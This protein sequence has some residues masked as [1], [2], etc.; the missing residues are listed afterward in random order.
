MNPEEK[1]RQ[2][3]LTFLIHSLKVPKS[4]ISVECSLP[5]RFGKGKRR[6]DILVHKP[7]NE[8]QQTEPWLLVECKARHIKIGEDAAW[9]TANYLSCI[10]SEHVM[11]TNGINSFFFQR[12]GESYRSASGLPVYSDKKGI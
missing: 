6:V 11:I 12:E 2:A 8:G 4:W 10:K 3:V 5:C 9:Q 1:V 7:N